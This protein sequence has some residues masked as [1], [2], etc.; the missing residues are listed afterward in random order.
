M[1][2][3]ASAASLAGW[4]ESGPERGHVMDV[5]IVDDTVYALTRIGVIRSTPELSAWTR[6][7]RFPMNTR[8]I[9]AIPGDNAVL[10]ITLSSVFRI[11]TEAVRLAFVPDGGAAVDLVAMKGGS[12]I[13]AVRAANAAGSVW[14][15]EPD[16]TSKA[17]LN[18]VDPWDLLADGKDI[19]VAT[20]DKGVWHSSDGGLTFDNVV[21]T[22]VASALTMLNG[23]VVV[24]WEGGRITDHKGETL[25]CEV[26][27]ATVTSM[28]VVGETLFAV[29]DTDMYPFT[30]LYACNELGKGVRVPTARS[31]EDNM[32]FQPT[33]IWPFN[34]SAAIVGTFRG[35]PALVGAEGLRIARTN[36][37][38]T[39]G[40][41]TNQV[42]NTLL[43]GFM[44]TGV[45]T[46]KDEGKTWVNVVKGTTSPLG[47]PPV[48]DTTDL[49]LDGEEIVVVDFDGI[50]VGKGTVWERMPGVAMP[51]AGR[52]NGLVEIAKDEQGRIWGRDF[53]DRLWLK[54]EAGWEQCVTTGVRRID[55]RGSHLLLST[56]SGYLKPIACDEPA[57][58]AWDLGSANKYSQLSRSAEGWVAS[59]QTL[60]Y[61]GQKVATLPDGDVQAL[62]VRQ[63]TNGKTEVLVALLNV[64]LQRCVD[65]VCTGI[66]TALPGPVEAVGWFESGRI[67]ALEKRGTFLLTGTPDDTGEVLL[68]ATSISDGKGGGSGEFRGPAPLTLLEIPPWRKL[69][70]PDFQDRKLSQ[71]TAHTSGT[72]QL[73]EP[74]PDEVVPA[75]KSALPWSV[76]I[77][78]EIALAATVVGA[79]VWLRRRRPRRHR[80]R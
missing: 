2:G 58:L 55:G 73:Q 31:D 5:A 61:E 44:S 11:G 15:I 35:G 41:A 19:W 76:I 22:G 47:V 67:W 65:G 27:R 79:A 77:G 30:A 9:A 37:H 49:Y 26:P 20:L 16:G 42:G 28:T 12:A 21:T 39:L 1:I 51:N 23:E 13:L 62:A 36:F 69:G 8:Q 57:E 38:A 48:S 56:E 63:G 80:P 66:S 52:Q 46:T 70:T 43:V 59:P 34:K 3:L 75:A 6:D 10:A 64:P 53:S 40:T 7:S 60:W 4:T 50:T 72:K 68:H 18:D 74:V 71:G 33:A 54:T 17:V 29:A 78:S 25:R 32:P 14:R 24:A 45:Y